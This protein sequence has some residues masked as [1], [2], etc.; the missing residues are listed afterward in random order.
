MPEAPLNRKDPEKWNGRKTAVILKKTECDGRV[1]KI[2]DV[3]PE[4]KKQIPQR[5]A[6]F[7]SFAD[8]L[9][10]VAFRDDADHDPFFQNEDSGTSFKDA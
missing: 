9:H 2:T 10:D 1:R 8:D 4:R 7:P 5:A 3:D 6:S